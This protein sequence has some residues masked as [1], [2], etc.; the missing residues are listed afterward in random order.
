MF[1]VHREC[2]PA[3]DDLAS[4]RQAVSKARREH[5]TGGYDYAFDELSFSVTEGWRCRICDT[6]FRAGEFAVGICLAYVSQEVRDWV[7]EAFT[8]GV[9][10]CSES[11]HG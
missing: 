7:C 3:D 2:K 5:P 1:N 4:R 6:A 10:P 11:E 8:P 9:Q